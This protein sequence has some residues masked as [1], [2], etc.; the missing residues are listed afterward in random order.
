MVVSTSAF[1]AGGPRFKSR[2][3]HKTFI[4]IICRKINKIIVSFIQFSYLTLTG[5]ARE[6]DAKT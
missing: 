2:R 6:D 5:E 4:I 1:G 3:G